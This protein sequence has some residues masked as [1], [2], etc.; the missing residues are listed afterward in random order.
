MAE[1]VIQIL[2][3]TQSQ[4]VFFAL[5]AGETIAFKHLPEPQITKT[6]A[7]G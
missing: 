5:G 4:S 2:D 1:R 3:D 6:L 7:K